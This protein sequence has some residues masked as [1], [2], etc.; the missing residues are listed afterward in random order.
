MEMPGPLRQ[1]QEAMRKC[2][3]DRLAQ[4]RGRRSTRPPV[5]K[6]R[7]PAVARMLK[8][9]VGR[10]VGDLPHVRRRPYKARWAGRAE[11]CEVALLL[12]SVAITD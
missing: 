8:H 2:G 6:S 11:A 7:Q 1:R 12:R 3:V 4:Y 10:E 5:V 9:Q